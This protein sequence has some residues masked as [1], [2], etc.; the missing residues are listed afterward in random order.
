MEKGHV[1]VTG[2]DRG[3]GRALCAGLLRQGWHVFAGQYMPDWHELS[4]L[5]EEYPQTLHTI[6][7]D[8]SSMES[9]RSAARAVETLTGHLDVLI[10]NAGINSSIR[11]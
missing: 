8:V 5:A 3:L 2:A 4:A 1:L 7:L 9:I 6:P 10:N 11:F